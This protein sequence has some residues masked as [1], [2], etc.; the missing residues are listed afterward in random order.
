MKRLLIIGLLIALA[1]GTVWAGG[2]KEAGEEKVILFNLS[3]H[4]LMDLV[5]YDKYFN[6]ELS[7]YELSPEEYEQY[8]AVLKDHP[9]PVV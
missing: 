7:D 1:V 8:T 4:G 2:A 9:S 5:G 6:G 3:G